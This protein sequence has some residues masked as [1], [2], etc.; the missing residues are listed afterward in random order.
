MRTNWLIRSK[1]LFILCCALREVCVLLHEPTRQSA[2]DNQSVQLNSAS[3]V[4]HHA[5][6][7]L[8]QAAVRVEILQSSLLKPGQ[9]AI[10]E[11]KK[12]RDDPDF[13][14]KGRRPIG[15][16]KKSQNT[17]RVDSI[18]VLHIVLQLQLT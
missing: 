5:T 2:P 13:E 8:S 9:T 4:K 14:I 3:F 17:S 11:G 16:S 7:E 12:P 6:V 10:L 1:K 15:R 18:F